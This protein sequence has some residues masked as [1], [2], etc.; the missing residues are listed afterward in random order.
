MLGGIIN[1]ATAS[2]VKYNLYSG[3]LA[4]MTDSNLDTYAILTDSGGGAQWTFPVPR[5]IGKI[6]FSGQQSVGILRVQLLDVKGNVLWQQDTSALAKDA[7]TAL[8]TPVAGVS[9]VKAYTLAGNT[10]SVKEIDVAEGFV[11]PNKFLVQDGQDIKS[12]IIKIPS[13]ELTATGSTAYLPASN[14]IDGLDTTE[15]ASSSSG[16]HWLQLQLATAKAIN[17]MD[18]TSGTNGAD[19]PDT[20]NIQ[21]SNDGVN[22]VTLYTDPNTYAFNNTAKLKKTFNFANE[23][24]YKYYRINVSA[25][26]SWSRLSEVSLFFISSKYVTGE[27]DLV[28]DLARQAGVVATA[29]SSYS[30]QGPE[31]A[32][33]GDPATLWNAGGASSGSWWQ[34]DF[35]GPVTIHRVGFRAD[36]M[37]G[38]TL[39]GSNDGVTFTEI[40]KITG[41]HPSEVRYADLT[42]PATYR[43]FRVTGI[44]P[45]EQTSTWKNIGSFEAYGI[46]SKKVMVLQKIGD[47]P[48]TKAMLDSCAMDDLSL[49]AGAMDSVVNDEVQLLGWSPGMYD[50]TAKIDMTPA[51]QI[52]KANWDIPLAHVN[53]VDYITLGY[54]R[55]E[56]A[57]LRILLSTDEG[58]IWKTM[59][60]GEWVSINPTD[61]PSVATKGLTPEAFN[62]LTDVEWKALMT[63]D[64]RIRIGY[65]LS[66][67]SNQET[68]TVNSLTMQADING[69]WEAAI[70]MEDYDYAYISNTRLEVELYTD[71]SYKINY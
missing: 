8:T 11:A 17:R 5:N 34:I 30:G 38:F 7:W 37:L 51:D 25:G 69:E 6:Y 54:E 55:S 65:F 58:V 46:G 27:L 13:S 9:V 36:L 29:S 41:M 50:Y 64:K 35:G 10:A 48:A 60:D 15:W 26:S 52:V 63:T 20:L 43:Y 56:G 21:G 67:N 22:F 57:N 14:A 70:H 40:Q 24:A 61:L 39:N 4:D 18:I 33:D 68:L 44:D 59:E 45:G 19:A 32:I 23:V 62:S 12:Y 49:I 1:E 2:I 66:M 53:H 71:G 42:V 47:A 16:A 31:R 3:T 28:T